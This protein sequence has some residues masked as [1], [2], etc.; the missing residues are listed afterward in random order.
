M[1]T[2]AKSSGGVRVEYKAEHRN[3]L[4]EECLVQ[5]EAREVTIN[6]KQVIRPVC[7]ECG[8]LKGQLISRA[9]DVQP[10][11]LPRGGC[12]SPRCIVKFFLDS[13]FYLLLGSYHRRRVAFAEANRPERSKTKVLDRYRTGEPSPENLWQA[14]HAN[15]KL[16]CPVCRQF[17]VDPLLFKGG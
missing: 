7:P 10:P 16:K 14:I 17:N 12:T 1:A 11:P 2:A 8:G 4:C 3:N 6:D 9:V 13:L 15:T 5:M